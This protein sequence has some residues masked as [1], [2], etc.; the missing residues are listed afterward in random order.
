M[1]AIAGGRPKGTDVPR[2]LILYGTTDGHTGKIAQRLGGMLQA[3][4]V[5]ADVVE[6]G[7][8]MPQPLPDDYAGIIVAAS[9]RES[10]Y[11]KSVERWVK[12]HAQALRGKP[13]A[14]VS[15][16]LGVL[17]DDPSV[18]REVATTGSSAGS[19]AESRAKLA[20]TRIPRGT[21]STPI[22]MTSARSPRNFIGSPYGRRRPRD[23]GEP[24]GA[25]L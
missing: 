16:C 17:Q 4:G 1:A 25:S 20:G 19:C 9:V 14:F 10:K 2:V 22:G 3:M 13:T 24:A 8:G 23:V 18:Q 21:T 12:S 6:A 5:G 7:G 15:V 11:Q